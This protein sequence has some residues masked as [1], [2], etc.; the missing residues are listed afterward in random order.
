MQKKLTEIKTRFEQDMKSKTAVFD[1]KV[2]Y[3]GR[4]NGLVTNLM[5]ELAEMGVEDKRQWGPRINELKNLIELEIGNRE[6]K[7]GEQTA[8]IDPTLPGLKPTIGGLHPITQVTRELTDYFTAMGFMALDGPE[9][10]SEFFNFEALNIPDWHPARE[11]Q[12]TFWTDQPGV[13]MRTHTSPMQIRAMLKYGAP[14]YA[15]VPG[16]VFRYEATDARHDHTF[17]QLEGL[18]IDQKISVANMNAFLKLLIEKIAGESVKIRI[19][20]GFFAFVEPG[21]E[22]DAECLV[23]HGK[24][25]RL[26][27]KTGWVESLGAGMVHPNVLRYGGVDPDKYSGFAFGVG[28]N[29]LAQLKFGY[30]DTRLVHQ[31]DLRFLRQF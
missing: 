3:L 7:G 19:R 1:L 28:I 26:C 30:E 9:V 8:K 4:K 27:K 5:K 16:R 20:P 6:L 12:D 14:L 31:N 22:V 11:M 24:G 15:V 23:C 13:L 29:R 18:V 17:Y 2:K 25:C 21:V 10:E